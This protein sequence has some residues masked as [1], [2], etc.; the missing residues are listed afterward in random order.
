MV[1]I[2]LEGSTSR[3]LD[4]FKYAHTSNLSSFFLV[5]AAEALA[6][7]DQLHSGNGSV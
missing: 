1:L 6:Y 2:F 7:Y 3:E 4:T 5:D